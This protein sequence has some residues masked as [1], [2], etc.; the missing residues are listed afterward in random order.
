M[1]YP[2]LIAFDLDGTLVDTEA[3]TLPDLIACLNQEF[4]VPMTEE[5]WLEDYHGMSGQPMLDKINAAY[6]T[7]LLWKDF[8]QVRSAR[9]PGVLAGGV[10]PAPGMLQA[11]RHLAAQGHQLCV[12]SNSDPERI[13]LTLKHITGQHSAGIFLDKLFDGHLFSATDSRKTPQ[14]KPSPFVYLEASQYY[15]SAPGTC[16]AVEDS[17]TGVQAAVSAGFRCIG[18]TGLSRYPEAEAEKLKGLGAHAIM[19]H[20]DDFIPLLETL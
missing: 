12:C 11:L 4:G 17:A 20:W 2:S 1:K 8:F 7:N 18:Y 14:P 16:L 15:G 3:L 13:A 9:L 5:R 6:G 19:R 10:A